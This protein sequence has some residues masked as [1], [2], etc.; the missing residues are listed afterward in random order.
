[1]QTVNYRRKWPLGL[2]LASLAGIAGALLIL[3][4]AVVGHA[5]LS[6]DDE[7]TLQ[8]YFATGISPPR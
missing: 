5:V 3:I 6:S 7:R 4:A 2:D 1:M 8:S